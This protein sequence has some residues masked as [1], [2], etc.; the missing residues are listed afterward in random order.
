MVEACNSG[1][2]DSHF[3]DCSGL[4]NVTDGIIASPIINDMA[5]D[6]GPSEPGAPA[7][8]P[9]GQFAEYGGIDPSLDP[10]MADAIRISLEE[11]KAAE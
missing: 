3:A 1:N 5:G 6:V 10:E 7:S 4:T 2:N 8:A 11:A 9:G